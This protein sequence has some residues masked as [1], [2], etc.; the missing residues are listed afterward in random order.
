[1]CLGVVFLVTTAVM[2]PERYISWFTDNV[3]KG[4]VAQQ[5]SNIEKEINSR[6]AA[7]EQKVQNTIEQEK[8]KIQQEIEATKQNINS[9]INA[10]V[11]KV[12]ADIAA[13]KQQINQTVA[14]LKQSIPGRVQDEVTKRKSAKGAACLTGATCQSGKCSFFK[15]T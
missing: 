3:V 6:Q 12:N 8:A 7:I 14:S 5:R 15:C 10:Q 1:V 4:L 9:Q 11:A 13:Y 2:Y